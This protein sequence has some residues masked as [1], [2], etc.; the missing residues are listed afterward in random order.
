MSFSRR[1]FVRGCAG[2]GCALA[3]G[4]SVG[5]LALFQPR[6]ARAGEAPRPHPARFWKKLDNKRVQCQLCPKQCLVEDRER[7]FCACAKPRRRI[8][9]SGLGPALRRARTPVENERV[10]LF[11]RI[12]VHGAGWPQTRVTYSPPRFSRTP[13]KPRSRSSTKHCL[14]QSCTARVVVQ[15]LPEPRRVR[16]WRLAARAGAAEECQTAHRST[17]CESTARPRAASNKSRREKL[18]VKPR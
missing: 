8:C 12:H 13:Q 11:Y 10:L 1:D 2:T 5:S 14:G 17:H 4:G 7:G 6:P 3:V 15:L 16:P 18:M 9:H